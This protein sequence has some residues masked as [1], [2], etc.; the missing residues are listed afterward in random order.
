MTAPSAIFDVM[1]IRAP[2]VPTAA[3]EE[4]ASSLWGVRAKAR[5]LSGERDA[6]FRLLAADGRQFVLKFANPAEDAGFRDMQVSALRHVARTD[7]DLAVPRVVDLPDGRAEAAVVVPGG[8]VCHA[9]LLSWIDG[10]PVGQSERSAGQRA[11]SGA[12]LARLQAALAGFAHPAADTRIVWDL[13]HSL[14]MREVADVLPS[15]VRDALLAILDAFE[16]EVTPIQPHLRRQVVHND[17]NHANI[18]VEPGAHD[19][20]AGVI[21]FGDMAET[22]VVFDVAIAAHSQKGGDMPIAEAA[23]H[24][25]RRYHALRPLLPEEIAI[26]PLLMATRAVMAVTLACY[27]HH[28]QPDNDHYKSSLDRIGDRLKLVAELRSP[29]VA[30]SLR[31]ACGATN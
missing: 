8:A 27:H 21:D 24:M 22:A 18:L 19:R 17:F 1:T 5:P 4:V 16:A 15:V 3:A 11:A 14:A 20:I 13:A 28:A 29:E 10:V 7:P 30:R 25:L 26:L 2:A 9:R 12:F 23:G 6:N 31:R